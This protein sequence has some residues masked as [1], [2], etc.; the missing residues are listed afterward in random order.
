MGVNL[1]LHCFHQ[2]IH[3]S[4]RCGPTAE[5]ELPGDEATT[6]FSFTLLWKR[7][8][9]GRSSVAHDPPRGG[10]S[11][12]HSLRQAIPAGATLASLSSESPPLLRATLVPLLRASRRA[13]PFA[14]RGRIS[15]IPSLRIPPSK[16]TPLRAAT[17]SEMISRE[18]SFPDARTSTHRPE[19]H[20]SRDFTP[21]KSNSYR[22]IRRKLGDDPTR[23][24]ERRFWLL[25]GRG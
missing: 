18:A 14:I 12:S 11:A 25:N 9:Q 6:S 23:W 13:H 2:G 19:G 24:L 4:Q 16:S 5:I 20:L 10:V 7:P 8:V 21:A 1:C 15:E 22:R 17:F 3:Q